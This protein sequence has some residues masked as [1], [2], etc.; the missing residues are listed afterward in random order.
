MLNL[1]S[2]AEGLVALK[3]FGVD[4][5]DALKCINNSS[6]RSLQ[7]TV[8]IPDEVL[9]NDFD[10]GFF[11]SLMRKDCGIGSKVSEQSEAAV[12]SETKR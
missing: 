11:L 5:S 8:R 1:L 12:A 10:Y 3:N 2:T 9:T 7:S 6:G 4:P